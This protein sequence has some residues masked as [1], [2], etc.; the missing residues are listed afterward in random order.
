MS[1]DFALD[2]IP[3]LLAG[4]QVTLELWL[5]SGVLGLAAAMGVAMARVSPRLIP[6]AGATG[7]ISVIRGTPL[8]VQIYI[9]YYGLGNVLAQYPAIRHSFIW[10]VLREGFWYALAALTI[11]MAAYGGEIIRG[12]ILAVP[13]GEV[14]A[15][16]S[17]GLKPWMLWRLL[18]LP[19]ALR[20]CLPA[21][22]GQLINLLKSTA[23][24]ST[25]TVMDLL[26]TANYIRMQSFR[27][28]EPLLAVAVVYT[29]LTLALSR[30]LAFLEAPRAAI[31]VP[32]S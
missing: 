26:G 32:P 29:V 2:M 17:L 18:I 7:F 30:G 9:M 23:L 5:L 10:P 4:L 28:Y 31:R 13:R 19:R 14:E 12:G 3:R 21:L 6:R 8:L 11:S 27:V 24:A 16:Q 20:I 1:L 22:V 25:I 15:G